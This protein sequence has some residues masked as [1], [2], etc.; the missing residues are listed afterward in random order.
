M[1]TVSPCLAPNDGKSTNKCNHKTAQDTLLCQGP[2]FLKNKT[3]F[4][5]SSE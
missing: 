5:H 2:A 1:G 3:D 4:V